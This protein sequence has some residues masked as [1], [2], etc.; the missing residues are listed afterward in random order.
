MLLQVQPL[1]KFDSWL[2]RQ[3]ANVERFIAMHFRNRSHL[4]ESV[5][6]SL[7]FAGKEVAGLATFLSDHSNR[8]EA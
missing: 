1:S 8:K 6:R 5:W 3:F 2:Q 7:L 4:P